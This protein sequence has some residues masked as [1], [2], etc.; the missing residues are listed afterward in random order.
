MVNELAC[1]VFYNYWNRSL[2]SHFGICRMFRCFE[3]IQWNA[4]AGFQ[5]DILNL[6]PEFDGQA[7]PMFTRVVSVPNFLKKVS[8]E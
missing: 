1:R 3:R 4:Q 5:H 6:A 7:C 2:Y 8:I